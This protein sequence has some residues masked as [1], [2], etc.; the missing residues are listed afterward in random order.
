[1]GTRQFTTEGLEDT[2]VPDDTWSPRTR[3]T[4]IGPRCFGGFLVQKEVVLQT[5]KNV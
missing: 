4:S 5:T 3:A 1:M 2:E